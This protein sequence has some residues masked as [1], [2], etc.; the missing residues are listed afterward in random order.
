M[1]VLSR[2][3]QVY[4]IIR[5]KN[6]DGISLSTWILTVYVGFGMSKQNKNGIKI[7]IRKNVHGFTN[8]SSFS[9]SIYKWT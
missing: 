8:F 5:H 6:A 9:D 2:F 4:K 3:T 1:S 7:K